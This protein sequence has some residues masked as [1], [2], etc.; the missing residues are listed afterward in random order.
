MPAC[1]SAYAS[2]PIPGPG[3]PV[4][5]EMDHSA[6]APDGS[7]WSI[8]CGRWG[9]YH[10]RQDRGTSNMA[11]RYRTR[12]V[13]RITALRAAERFARGDAPC[14]E[15]AARIMDDLGPVFGR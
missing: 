12:A 3:I 10:L 15:C 8:E 14:P 6:T 2:R 1:I 4:P 9:I 5:P 13:G 7:V 11:A